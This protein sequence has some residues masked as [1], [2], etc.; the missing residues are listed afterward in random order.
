MENKFCSDCIHYKIV[1]KRRGYE[2][3]GCEYSVRPL[4]KNT[5]RCKRHFEERKDEKH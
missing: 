1:P 3:A 4:R 5:E 2:L